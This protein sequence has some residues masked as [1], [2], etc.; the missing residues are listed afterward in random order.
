M[1][2]TF[3]HFSRYTVAGYFDLLLRLS[4]VCEGAIV[5]WDGSEVDDDFLAPLSWVGGSAPDDLAEVYGDHTVTYSLATAFND[6]AKVTF[7]EL[8]TMDVVVVNGGD[9]DLQNTEL[10]FNGNSTL[11]S[12][13][14]VTLGY[15]KKGLGASVILTDFADWNITGDLVVGDKKKGEFT[16]G[17]DASVGVGGDLNIGS[18]NKSGAVDSLYSISGGTLDVTFD[19]NIE[20]SSSL[21][22]AGGNI[23]IGQNL[24]IGDLASFSQTAGM[25]DVTG[26]VDV[27]KGT[28][29]TSG[30]V[31]VSGDVVLK[32]GGWTQS[33]G[34]VSVTGGLIMEVGGSYSLS[35]GRLA[36]DVG[37]TTQNVASFTWQSGGTLEAYSAGST[38]NVNG[39]L[40][41][42]TGAVLD[43]NGAGEELIVTGT[44]T[45]DGLI[46]DGYDLMFEDLR[47]LSSVAEGSDVLITAGVFGL[48]PDITFNFSGFDEVVNQTGASPYAAYTPSADE[49]VCWFQIVGGELSVHW[50]LQPIHEP[51]YSHLLAIGSGALLLRRRR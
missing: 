2:K 16:H 47:Q 9:I 23:T 25:L 45:A 44:F 42:S 1:R 36:T 50:H 17:G 10:Q 41:A 43:L 51:H 31:S 7:G 49:D 19:V 15:L 46:I 39:D 32:Q 22:Q 8:L 4:S 35:G 33:N 29:T 48:N 14:S 27:F 18:A 6:L 34:T 40:T 11:T 12:S 13:G 24:N 30:S 21:A 3:K 37:I 20:G 28:I 5:T 38:I 26:D